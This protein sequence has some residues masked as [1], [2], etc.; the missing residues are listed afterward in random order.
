MKV[1]NFIEDWLNS[2]PTGEKPVIIRTIH[3]KPDGK[4]CKEGE[5]VKIYVISHHVKFAVEA[6]KPEEEPK[7]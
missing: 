4:I 3:K 2:E 7:K 1:R 5:G 6:E